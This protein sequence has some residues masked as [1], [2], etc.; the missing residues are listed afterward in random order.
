MN[1]AS[2]EH[3][4]AGII[5]VGLILFGGVLLW[6]RNRFSQPVMV[7]GLAVMAAVYIAGAAWVAALGAPR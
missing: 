2:P 4:V 7:A 3:F 1:F 5:A 6:G